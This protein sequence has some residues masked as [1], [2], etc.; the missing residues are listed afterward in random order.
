MIK[1]FKRVISMILVVAML[2]SFAGIPGIADYVPSIEAH[3]AATT[4]A[5]PTTADPVDLVYTI[6]ASSGKPNGS[7]AATNQATLDVPPILYS[8]GTNIVGSVTANGTTYSG[9][10]TTLSVTVP[11]DVL[12]DIDGDDAVDDIYVRLNIFT[13]DF[14][15]VTDEVIKYVYGVDGK[16]PYPDGLVDT[17]NNQ[18]YEA[19]N[20]T[21]AMVQNTD[22]TYTVT[23]DLSG[24]AA[25]MSAEGYM[26]FRIDYIVMHDEFNAN[27]TY[28]SDGV[29]TVSELGMKSVPVMYSQYAASVVSVPDFRAVYNMNNP[30][31]AYVDHDGHNN[32]FLLYFDQEI[33]FFNVLKNSSV[34]VETSFRNISQT[35]TGM[36]ENEN[37][38][39]STL[40]SSV[41]ESNYGLQANIADTYNIQTD[42][43]NGD[44]YTHMAW[45]PS[46]N[47]Y[48]NDYSDI[49]SNAILNSHMP[50]FS[51]SMG[52]RIYYDKDKLSDG[53]NF[54]IYTDLQNFG[55]ISGPNAIMYNSL[56]MWN[57]KFYTNGAGPQYEYNGTAWGETGYSGKNVINV[58]S[59][60]WTNSIS[61]KIKRTATDLTYTAGSIKTKTGYYTTNYWVEVPSERT[62]Y[63]VV[64]AFITDVQCGDN[65]GNSK[66]GK[67]ASGAGV[68]TN[69]HIDLI[70][71]DRSTSRNYIESVI[72]DNYIKA[73]MDEEWWTYYRNS[74]LYAYYNLGKL[75]SV[76]EPLSINSNFDGTWL[77]DSTKIN[78]PVYKGAN[79]NDLGAALQENPAYEK[80]NS[81][82]G[83]I[84]SITAGSEWTNY[85]DNSLTGA[86]FYTAD[87]WADYVAARNDAVHLIYACYRTTNDY[88]YGTIENMTTTDDNE[89][90]VLEF[91]S[92]TKDQYAMYCYLQYEFEQAAAALRAAKAALKLK[93][94]NYTGMATAIGNA[95]DNGSYEYITNHNNA[96]YESANLNFKVQSSDYTGT[97]YDYEGNPVEVTVGK[98]MSQKNFSTTSASA[99]RTALQKRM[100]VY[101]WNGDANG[102]GMPDNLENQGTV[103]NYAHGVTFNPRAGQYTLDT[104]YA[105]AENETKLSGG[106]SKYYLSIAYQN[107]VTEAISNINTAAA[108]LRLRVNPK[109]LGT[110]I[111]NARYVDVDGTSTYLYSLQGDDDTY[112]DTDV[113]TK[114]SFDAY[115][116]A[117]KVSVTALYGN[118]SPHSIESSKTTIDYAN[119]FFARDTD[120]A[121]GEPGY[122]T[123]DR[124]MKIIDASGNEVTVT[125][126]NRQEEYNYALTN[127][128]NAQLLLVKYADYSEALKRI[129][130]TA[131]IPEY[132]K[133]GSM[134]VGTF[135]GSQWYTADTWNEFVTARNALA[136][137]LYVNGAANS[138]GY[139][140]DNGA[141]SS[142][143]RG[144]LTY[145]DR[146]TITNAVNDFDTAKGKLELKKMPEYVDGSNNTY[147]ALNAQVASKVTELS[148][149]TAVY[150]IVDGALDKTSASV[151]YYNTAELEALAAKVTAITAD[152][153][154]VGNYA[155]Y[156]AAITAFNN[157]YNEVKA[158]PNSISEA[159]WQ[160]IFEHLSVLA[161]GTTTSITEQNILANLS[162]LYVD[163]DGSVKTAIQNILTAY[164]NVK[165]GTHLAEGTTVLASNSQAEI[166]EQ[167]ELLYNLLNETSLPSADVKD[168]ST[169]VRTEMAKTF[170]AYNPFDFP[171][172]NE[173]ELYI[174]PLY[175]WEDDGTSHNG[176]SAPTVYKSD[177]ITEMT[178][179]V[180]TA[181]AGSY[182]LWTATKAEMEK[183]ANTLLVQAGIAPDGTK[184]YTEGTTQV[185]AKQN[186]QLDVLEGALRA[187]S[188]AFTYIQQVT[189]VNPEEGED[190]NHSYNKFTAESVAEI[191]GVVEYA[192][193]YLADN[194]LA[195]VTETTAEDGTVTYTVEVNESASYTSQLEID[196]LIFFILDEIEND[197]TDRLLLHV[198][199]TETVDG[200]TE[201]IDHFTWTYT[202][203]EDGTCTA[204]PTLDETKFVGD[205]S[206]ENL[207]HQKIEKEGDDN[208]FVLTNAYYGFL[209]QQINT[210]YSETLTIN[211]SSLTLK[212][213]GSVDY[214]NEANLELLSGKVWIRDTKGTDDTAD[215]TLELVSNN[216]QQSGADIFEGE[217]WSAYTTALSNAKAGDRTYLST[218][219]GSIDDL[220]EKLYTARINLKLRNFTA[221][222]A[223]ADAQAFAANFNAVVNAT[224]SVSY[225]ELLETT[226]DDGTVTI[227]PTPNSVNVAAYDGVTTELTDR[228]DLFVAMYASNTDKT[229][230]YASENEM[231][232][233]AAAIKALIDACTLKTMA[234]PAFKVGYNSLIGYDAETDSYGAGFIA[235][236]YTPGTFTDKGYAGGEYDSD[237]IAKSEVIWDSTTN[238]ATTVSFYDDTKTGK[239]KW[240]AESHGR[241]INVMLDEI[242][243]KFSEAAFE[244]VTDATTGEVKTAAV[245]LLDAAVRELNRAT[246]ALYNY[247]TGQG[248]YTGIYAEDLQFAVE[249]Q[250]KELYPFLKAQIGVGENDSLNFYYGDA[251][252]VE[253]NGTSYTASYYVFN[254]TM[255]NRTIKTICDTL[256]T[257]D[258]WPRIY[259]VNGMTSIP[260]DDINACSVDGYEYTDNSYAYTGE[261]IVN[262]DASAKIITILNMVASNSSTY[263]DFLKT[264]L[265]SYNTEHNE[266]MLENILNKQDDGITY[267]LADMNTDSGIAS[268]YDMRKDPSGYWFTEGKGKTL[269]DGRTYYIFSDGNEDVKITG[270]INNSWFTND[271]YSGVDNA[272]NRELI[273]ADFLDKIGAFYTYPDENYTG[274]HLD[275]ETNWTD[276]ESLDDYFS[277]NNTLGAFDY[278]GYDVA[279]IL[280]YGWTP[281]INNWFIEDLQKE[282]D[283]YDYCVANQYKTLQDLKLLP[284]TD[285]YREV[286]ELYWESQKKEAAF[287]D[288]NVGITPNSTEAELPTAIFYHKLESNETPANNAFISRLLKVD[289][290]L[291]SNLDSASGYV[292]GYTNAL[293]G[294]YADDANY[295]NYNDFYSKLLSDYEEGKYLTI[296]CADEV[297]GDYDSNNK[298]LKAELIDLMA[299][300]KLKE[301]D[302]S[303]LTALVTAFLNKDADAGLLNLTAD[304]KTE[305]GLTGTFYD[306][307]NYTEDSLKA[308]VAALR[309][310]TDSATSRTYSIISETLV[311]DVTTFGFEYIFET[312]DQ[313]T[314][315]ST[316]TVQEEID[317]ACTAVAAAIN[318]LA[319]KPA[320]LDALGNAID[321][322]NAL[323]QS[324]YDTTSDAGKAAWDDVQAKKKAAEELKAKDGL[325]I[326]DQQDINNAEQALKNAI[327]ALKYNADSTAPVMTVGTTPSSMSMYYNVA[328]VADKDASVAQSATPKTGTFIMPVDT[329][330]SLVVYTNELNPRILISLQDIASPLATKPEKFSV[331]AKKTS[332]ASAQLITGTAIGND[333]PADSVVST[334]DVGSTAVTTSTYKADTAED[335]DSNSSLFAILAPNFSA[336][337]GQKQAVLYQLSASDSGK[338]Q[339]NIVQGTGQ[340]N[341]V[342]EL[343]FDNGAVVS[344][345]KAN[346]ETAPDTITVYVYYMDNMPRDDAGEILNDEG[347]VGVTNSD[348]STHAE[349][350]K[351][352]YGNDASAIIYSGEKTDDG[353]TWRANFILNRGFNSAVRVWEFVDAESSFEIDSN[354]DG[355]IDENDDSSGYITSTSKGPIYYDPTFGS[356]N[357]GSFYYVLDENVATDAAIISAYKNTKQAK[358]AAGTL[359]NDSMD[360]EAATTAKQTML[361]AINAADSTVFDAM[362][363]SDRFVRYGASDKL[364][365]YT[366]WAQVVN[367]NLLTKTTDDTPVLIFVHVL[368]RWGNVVNRIIEVTRTDFVAPV[369]TTNGAGMATVDEEGGSGLADVGIWTNSVAEPAIVT[370]SVDDGNSSSLVY[371]D[372]ISVVENSDVTVYE[373]E[374]GAT[375]VEASENT[376]T[377]EGLTPGSTYQVGACDGAGNVTA[378]ELHAD[379][380]GCVEF[381]IETGEDAEA[382]NEPMTFSLNGDI[383]VTINTGI[384]S[385]VIDAEAEGNVIA[386]KTITHFIT[387]EAEVTQLKVINLADGTEKVFTPST[388]RIYT[389][390]D[391]TIK[392]ATKHKLTEGEHSFKVYAMVD[393]EYETIGVNFS[394]NATLKTV[395]L[396]LSVLGMGTITLEYSGASPETIS[397]FKAVNVPYGAKVKI[398]AKSSDA[399]AKFYYW[400]NDETD[401]V[402][403]VNEEMS[404]TA[405]ASTD[406]D[407]FFSNS[408]SISSTYKYVVYVNNAGN[409]IKSVEL[410]DGGDYVV[411]LG[412]SLP[413]H[414][415]QGWAMTKDEVLASEEHIV[416]VRPIYKLET[417]NTV[418]ITEG[419]YT[420]SGAGT[421]TSVDN[422]RALVTINASATNDAGEEFLYWYDEET[423]DIVSYDRAYAFN[424]IKDVVLTPVY[425]DASTVTAKPV[426]RIADVRYD[427]SSGKANF[428][429][430]R[431]IGEEYTLVETG[432]VVTRTESI[433]ANEE[434][435]VVGG[436]STA[437]GK[438]QSVAPY[439]TYSVSVSVSA[440][441]TVW[442]RAYAICRTADGELIEVYSDVV[443]YTNN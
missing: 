166:N 98:A 39:T 396:S 421:Y 353:K 184:N 314:I 164:S 247:T 22:G 30:L 279:E 75:D 207:L 151:N 395:P 90:G 5:R 403:N 7:F 195:T 242:Y 143:T 33:N 418:T 126:A 74:V 45:S 53:L 237:L 334:A 402:A 422:Q 348:G 390:E 203:A 122:Y 406:Y 336:T 144:R 432:I 84:L 127:A 267:V 128:Q 443:P 394:F 341:K 276:P 14:A 215:D 340:D 106:A 384:S 165:K 387:T 378:P 299:Q 320:E 338:D 29:I 370:N 255:A 38:T 134:A 246:L 21:G 117:M 179:Y 312:K 111:E 250:E 313:G 57:E 119:D 311:I 162:D 258:K 388:T 16:D 28:D 135:D 232:E 350:L 58:K 95:T 345:N 15:K 176:L 43:E 35:F 12:G 438:S 435:F 410:Y 73:E 266:W 347:I 148:G 428:Y 140:Y 373:N 145:A 430:E 118:G 269:A 32:A 11:G 281:E 89:D 130:G 159:G 346:P 244:D 61:T 294:Q 259:E 228:I 270:S 243:S 283:A 157:K 115:L 225:Y 304:Q 204:A 55:T 216:G 264:Y 114:E 175:S 182:T 26:L 433:A 278:S 260:G 301:F 415:F 163:A 235:G 303:K 78:N 40:F 27:K 49:D 83:N 233:E 197:S 9:L 310:Y 88:N 441:E 217:S 101:D 234:D 240:A 2:A 272:F 186:I 322:A 96:T 385:S 47:N 196:K 189:A 153:T 404:F 113:Y 328:A 368:D 352:E 439:G 171:K 54:D 364:G 319:L 325:T 286:V 361:A 199:P 442:V 223:Y 131:Y 121:N 87:T 152:K 293:P 290:T 351:S 103:F 4:P 289:T 68:S 331:T 330:Y 392:W 239:E 417:V 366:N 431:S 344:L 188:R 349:A 67:Y 434:S 273:F 42:K 181:E 132:D 123:S 323:V 169:S 440:E 291:T 139:S 359:S 187:A 427:G 429:A 191:K 284:A 268:G 93:A 200:A 141:A 285:A 110:A 183:A 107:S 133:N 302:Y 136:N 253:I 81:G 424:C 238:T 300:L 356:L 271:S 335:Y 158:A 399:N 10:D 318:A 60:D 19:V 343:T 31:G 105:T 155:E 280:C 109:A 85:S 256:G 1:D 369:V 327:A 13:L 380:N 108:A 257:A 37:Q 332:G 317:R 77:G 202:Y 263:K 321:K 59:I 251:N 65:N 391:G 79:Y 146:A 358:V 41:V 245:D 401:R 177:S 437:K 363:I 376:F 161:D 50:K 112:D 306:Y 374:S 168:A 17:S 34:A 69:Y 261:S 408:Q 36:D 420:V 405:V 274:E 324:D 315:Y 411:P 104:T 210:P 3:A 174:N 194:N 382:V 64:N 231:R 20:E 91:R 62:L 190:D 236:T 362:K 125:P 52:A 213:D 426:V 413:D 282:Q 365:N 400:L 25:N 295:K 252:Q 154:L 222:P 46:R 138:A 220:A 416:V 367:K 8:D 275:D 86:Y 436:V 173:E 185:L 386:N 198:N 180:T 160:D 265:N 116:L 129:N 102:N 142:Y 51:A 372:G 44:G 262:A 241:E 71:V 305:L 308:V 414:V 226:A 167:V 398:A 229:A 248:D 288:S 224:V 307:S 227:V 97:Y 23:F 407:A 329:G 412:P 355:K 379:E 287:S 124:T 66:N 218:A 172:Y 397:N 137:I 409:V 205:Y 82:S 214:T 219:Q 309:N 249:M 92:G 156:E 339:Q 371:A 377:V 192:K 296:D 419:N 6:P 48:G 76:S 18:I 423:K 70:P 72:N 389:N 63:N 206:W 99:L 425:G 100:Y 277:G 230:P 298:S 357:T 56:N 354:G 292:N 381:T 211:K 333:I 208:G 337:G 150:T 375:V 147:D 94:A 393:G 209:D 178:G 193:K 170:V 360:Y 383:M 149:K 342:K 212:D 254:E 297:N 316:V 326:L 120:L 24:R 201:F 80:G 221:N